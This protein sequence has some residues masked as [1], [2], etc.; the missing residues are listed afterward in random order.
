MCTRGTQINYNG[1]KYFIICREFGLY[2]Y[3]YV[4]KEVFDK[5]EVVG[6]EGRPYYIEFR[7]E[8]STYF[9][10][11]SDTIWVVTNLKKIHVD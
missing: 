3:L 9:D 6:W 5:I 1:A 2:K 8:I 10:Y 4:E 7:R 11:L